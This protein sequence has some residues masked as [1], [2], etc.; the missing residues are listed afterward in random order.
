MK[1]LAMALAYAIGVCRIDGA[2]RLPLVWEAAC[3]GFAGRLG[4]WMKH[5]L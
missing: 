1:A 4:K 3:D 2:R 5:P